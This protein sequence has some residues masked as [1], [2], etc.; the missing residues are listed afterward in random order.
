MCSYNRIDRI[1]SCSNA[2]TL[3]G[4]LKRGLGFGGFVV[5]DWRATRSTALTAGLDIEQPAAAFMNA[6]AIQGAIRRGEATGRDV[7]DAVHRILTSLYAV[8][9]MDEPAEAWSW[10][11]LLANVSSA[12]SIA[13]ARRLAARSLVMLRNAGGVLP[14]TRD[15]VQ[16]IALIGF[17]SD[18]RNAY[19]SGGGSGYVAP[20]FL[21]TPLAPSPLARRRTASR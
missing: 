4:D 12:A 17:C 9:A 14:L 6:S 21:S 7:D 20:S 10:K 3:A 5:S 18:Y 19:V 2:A 11:K 8:G 16:S 13:S 15:A 1:Y